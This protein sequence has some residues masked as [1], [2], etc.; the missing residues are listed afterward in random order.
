[1]L[2]YYSILALLILS[3]Q[4]FTQETVTLSGFVYDSETGEALIGTNIFVLGQQIG[5]STNAYGFYSIS[6]PK[7]SYLFR[8]AFVGY[9][10]KDETISLSKDT[11]LNIELNSETLN[12]ETI[13]V[14]AEAGDANIKKAEMG[15]VKLNPVE[16]KQVP[17]LF[18]EQ[19]VLK[20]IQ[21]LPGVTAASEGQAG[22][23]VRG[24][25][26]DQNL[27]L[28]DEAPV[29]NASHLMG[30]FSVFNSDAINSAKLIKGGGPPE[31]G[32][33]LSSVLD[34]K[35][36]EGNRKNFNMSGGIGAISSRLAVEGPIEDGRGSYFVSGRRTYADLLMRM[37]S[38]DLSDLTLYFYDLNMKANYHLGENDYLY[39][40]GYLGRDVLGFNDEF[41]LNWG[42]ATMTL[43][44]NHLF[45]DKI[46]SNTSLIYSNFDYAVSFENGGSLTD[47]TSSIEDFNLK[48]NFYY[49]Y[50]PQHKFSA[51]LDVNYHTF[52]PGQISTSGETVL[53]EFEIDKKY[54]LESAFY[55]GHEW[56]TNS[57]LSLNYGLRYSNF[58]LLGPGTVYTFDEEDNP[59]SSTEYSGWETI[60]TYGGFEPRFTINVLLDCASSL[61][62]SLSR[63]QQYIYLISNSSGGPS[64]DVWHPST[65][66]VRPGIADQISLGY[67]RNFADNNIETSLEV[68]YKILQNQ[69][70]YQNG[71]DLL[72][73]QFVESQLVFGDGLSYGAEF[74]LKKN[75][76]RL[77]GW[78]SY[79]ISRT[80]REFADINNGNAFP[81][82]NDR[83]HDISLTGIYRL[84]DKWSFSANWVYNTG[85]A[86]T[87]PSGKYLIDGQTVNYYTER[88]G[89]RLPDYH[90]LDL[91]ATYNF[92]NSGRYESN[93]NFSLYNAYGQANPYT[94]YF[95]ES[96]DDPNVTEA[97]KVYLF[98]FFPSISYNFKW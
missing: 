98:T 17:V 4:A 69:V 83:T 65:S 1:M 80:E 21:L 66:I 33:R 84:N 81:A 95:R 89:Y 86:Y 53:N 8:F 62:F 85:Q 57:W 10:S 48:Q 79:A 60:K 15:T 55:L 61:K 35:M 97:V 71:A 91:G 46:F 42:N 31:Y 5:G 24:G 45:S 28:L 29:Y 11:K 49:S 26:P 76:G 73:N 6:V 37:S 13:I 96:K 44:W 90:R 36:K 7:G 30:F 68:Y 74:Y 14:T 47:I 54:A 27:I 64:L 56:Q 94:I 93:I 77:T 2:K 18:G 52:I 78:M 25:D 23:Y 12:T 87:F 16:I 59:E 38:S 22:F 41:G 92:E 67:F 51:G 58:T 82:T 72:L 19:D 32:G 40:S 39:L 43:R 34:I 63:N 70:D 20:T 88:N 50:N 9:E 3:S 75:F